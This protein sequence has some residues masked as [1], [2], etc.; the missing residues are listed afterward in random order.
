MM[1][2]MVMLKCRL[3]WHHT[4]NSILQTPRL[5]FF[6]IFSGSPGHM[7]TRRVRHPRILSHGSFAVR[8]PIPVG[9][10]WGPSFRMTSSIR[11]IAQFRATSAAQDPSK[12]IKKRG[13]PK[14]DQQQE[15]PQNGQNEAVKRDA[16][17]DELMKLLPRVRGVS[18]DSQEGLA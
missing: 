14:R 17:W 3:W 8:I 5:V 15:V 12:T 13:R 1:R 10:A 11:R 16:Q 4:P 7:I 6:M 9:P 18:T 2:L